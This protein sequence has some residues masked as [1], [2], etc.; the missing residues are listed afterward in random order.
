MSRKK[1]QG[2]SWGIVLKQIRIDAGLNQADIAKA[3]YEGNPQHEKGN[4][5]LIERNKISITEDKIRLW[6]K[7]CGKDMSEF[8]I[9]ATSL[10]ASELLKKSL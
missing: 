8:Y 10:E 7:T 6:I 1:R 2:I 5:S 9:R 3:L 4:V